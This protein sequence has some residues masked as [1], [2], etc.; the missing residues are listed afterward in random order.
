MPLVSQIYSEMYASDHEDYNHQTV[1]YD[2]YFTARPASVDT[3]LAY[4]NSDPGWALCSV[5]GATFRL[6]DGSDSPES[7]SGLCFA[8]DLERPLVHFAV[9]LTAEHADAQ[10]LVRIGYWE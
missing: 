8:Q 6:P 4:V 3:S 10:S 2:F 5:I 1:G 7:L 9:Q